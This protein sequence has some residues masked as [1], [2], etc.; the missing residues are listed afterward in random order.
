MIKKSLK[1]VDRHPYI[2]YTNQ[3]IA[4]DKKLLKPID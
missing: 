3:A 2:C 1:G 4:R